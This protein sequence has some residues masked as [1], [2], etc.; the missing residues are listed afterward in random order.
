[1]IE[2]RRDK[3]EAFQQQPEEPARPLGRRPRPPVQVSN[4]PLQQV[5]T[6]RKH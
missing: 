5:E 6:V 1:M 4:E 2:T 3:L